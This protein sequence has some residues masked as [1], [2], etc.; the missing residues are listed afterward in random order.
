MIITAAGSKGDSI[1]GV[2]APKKDSHA[3]TGS[4][5]TL[6]GKDIGAVEESKQCFQ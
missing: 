3:C 5:S 1:M 6:T 4:S 2:E